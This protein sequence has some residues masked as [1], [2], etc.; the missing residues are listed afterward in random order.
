MALA[1]K[2]N[3]NRRPNDTLSIWSKGQL[4][5]STSLMN[6]PFA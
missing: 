2:W 6:S 1:G 5:P 4:Y 3:V